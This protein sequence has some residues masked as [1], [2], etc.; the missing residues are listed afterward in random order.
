MCHHSGDYYKEHDR[1]KD[2]YQR[3]DK[4]KDYRSFD[5]DGDDDS[6]MEWIQVK[7]KNRSS[8]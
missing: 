1:S 6:K 3:K 2:Y 7:R 8:R 4:I 5:N